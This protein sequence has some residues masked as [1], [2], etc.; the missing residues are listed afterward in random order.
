MTFG[1]LYLGRCWSA[2]PSPPHPK[3]PLQWVAQVL[4]L[5]EKHFLALAGVDATVYIRFLR[6]CCQSAWI[7]ARATRVLTGRFAV[8][9]TL[10]HA[11]TVRP[12]FSSQVALTECI[13]PDARRN[14]AHRTSS[15][16]HL[17]KR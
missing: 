1:S 7:A 5:T 12:S 14:F 10:L 8:Y 13:V 6:G 15:A 2:L 17:A 3:W 4:K 11:C 9:F 16:F